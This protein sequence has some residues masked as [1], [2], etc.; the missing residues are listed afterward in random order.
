[1]GANDR[2]AHHVLEACRACGIRVPEEVAVLGVDNDEMLCQLSNPALSSI[3]QGARQIG[4]DAAVLLDRMMQGAKPRRQHYII[5]PIGIVTRRS[6]DV[7]AIEDSI[8]TDAMT[9]IR[10]HAYTGIKVADVVRASPVSRSTLESR[11]KATVGSSIH[12]VI[13]KIQLDQARHLLTETNLAI[14]EI[15]ANTGFRSVQH[16]TS[17]FGESFGQS[18]AKYKRGLIR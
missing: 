18:P 2:R 14:K 6:T 4:Y 1:M 10:S 16:M 5:A 11:F 17:L 12:A 3:E 7:L 13:R 8:T 9:F 15:A